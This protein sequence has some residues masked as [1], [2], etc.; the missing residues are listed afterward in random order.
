[1]QLGLESAP[2]DTIRIVLDDLTSGSERNL[3]DRIADPAL[4]FVRGSILDEP[5]VDR[6]RTERLKAALG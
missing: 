4:R 5:L 2:D 6:L 1:M 3:R